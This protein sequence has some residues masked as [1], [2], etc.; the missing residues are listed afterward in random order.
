MK[1]I[2]LGFFALASILFI[3]ACT[4]DDKPTTIAKTAAVPKSV[5]P[6]P[7]YKS[8][9][10]KPGYHFEV[11]SWGKGVDTLGGYLLLMSDSIK[12]NYKSISLER[13]GI[14]TDAWNMDLDNDGNPELYIQYVARKNVNDLNVYEFAGNSFDKISFPGLNSD[15]KKGYQG[16]D[17]FFIKNGDLFRSVPVITTDSGKTTTVIKTIQ[18]QLRGNSFSTSEVKE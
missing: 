10:I 15:I 13:K 11:V 5:N 18:Y 7:F 17:K 14:I 1:G 9:E 6:F 2:K 8:I 4:N 12:N 16:N 3:A